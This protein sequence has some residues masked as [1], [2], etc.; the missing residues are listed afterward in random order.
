MSQPPGTPRVLLLVVAAAIVAT[1]AWATWFWRTLDGRLPT[2]ADYRA[3]NKRIRANVRPG[4]VI[5]LAPG[6]ATRGKD[7]LDAAEVRAS[8]DLATDTYPDTK[9]QWLVALADAP[10]VDL[11]ALRTALKARATASGGGDRIG[12]LWVEAF[13]IAGPVTKLRLREALPLALVSLAGAKDEACRWNAAE[14]RH[15]CPRGGWNTV[16]AGWFDVAGNPFEAFWAHP[17][18]GADLVLR[19]TDAP[20][21]GR[22]DLR[23]ALTS[24]VALEPGEPVEV[25]ARVDGTE[26][27]R[28]SVQPPQ[29]R[30]TSAS[31][32]L[33][34]ADPAARGLLELRIRARRAGRRHFALDG[35]VAAP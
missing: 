14:R 6:W 20:V 35:W 11:E 15:E 29:Q 5:V 4:D 8:A 33:P 3:V 13:D 7:F 10:R 17:V 34:A 26:V 27:G 2:D 32:V 30:P 9:R 16:Y 31:F 18:D 25:E 28:F 12:G 22:L 1:G 23:G 19:W 21:S 24:L